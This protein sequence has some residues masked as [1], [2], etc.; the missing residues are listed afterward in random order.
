MAK[1]KQPE[2][3][4]VKPQIAIGKMAPTL[5]SAPNVVNGIVK[6]A[7]GYL[8]SSV[9][10]VVKD[11]AGEPVRA[12]KTNKI[13]QFAI[14]TPLPNG[15]YMLELEAEGHNFDIV[16]IELEGEVLAPLEIRAND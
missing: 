16:Q 4:V 10:I 7:A 9:I 2:A 15:I 6:D 13:G 1:A 3:H 12:L 11:K 14:S 5:T 8:L